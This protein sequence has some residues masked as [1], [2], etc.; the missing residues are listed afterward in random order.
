M[1]SPEEIQEMSETL[2]QIY[3]QIEDDLLLNVAGRFSIL[4]EIPRETVAEWQ[5]RKLME[6]GAL[7]QECIKAIS[8]HSGKTTRE[9]EGILKKAGYEALE[10]DEKVYKMALSDGLLPYSPLPMKASPALQ[11]IIRG[12]IDNTRTYLNTVNTT[13]LQSAQDEFL[14]IVNQTYLET[15]LGITDYNTAMRKAVR[16]LADK[17][18]TGADYVSATGRRTHNHIDVAVR[19]CIVTSTSQTAGV[20]QEQRAKEWGSNLV[21]VSSHM[22]ARPSHAVWQGK[23]YSLDGSTDKYPNLAQATGYGTVTGLCGANCRH[24]FFAYLEGV[25]EKT[26]KP[27][28][29]EANQKAYEQ[30]QEQRRLEREVR[31]QKRRI[32][33]A[34]ATGDGEMKFKSQLAL[35]EKEMDLNDFLKKSGRE[36]RTNRQQVYGFGRSEAMQ[37]VWAKRKAQ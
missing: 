35:K 4:D 22:D 21:E 32:L 37:A 34:D 13:A 9:V 16:Q 6:L 29:L 14:R 1:L 8:K 23:I 27:Y 25:S 28:D 10:Y 20:M 18:I 30:S 11:Q 12:A 3:M 17:G 7:R 2:I 36:P 33:T 24:F 19:R 5:T 15:S 31:K 26:Y